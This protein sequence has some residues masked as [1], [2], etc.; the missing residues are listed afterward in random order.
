MAVLLLFTYIEVSWIQLV[1]IGVGRLRSICFNL[2]SIRG[3]TL[4]CFVMF[5]QCLH[6]NMDMPETWNTSSIDLL[7]ILYKQGLCSETNK[8]RA[9]LP[10]PSWGAEPKL[11]VTKAQLLAMDLSR[12]R[13]LRS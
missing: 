11:L 1:L 6:S 10:T 7:Q 2:F 4:L 12:V 13:L 5:C 3:W 8:L 9:V